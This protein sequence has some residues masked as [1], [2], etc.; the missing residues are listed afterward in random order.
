MSSDLTKTQKIILKKVKAEEGR[1]YSKN[2]YN[3]YEAIN[4][5]YGSKRSLSNALRD[6]ASKEFLCREKD[7]NSY[8]YWLDSKGKKII[9]KINKR[10][11]N[12]KQEEQDIFEYEDGI[13]QFVEYFEETDEGQKQVKEVGVGRHYVELD[14]KR[15]EKFHHE[16]ADDLLT[17]PD[18]VL[19]ACREAVN[20]LPEVNEDVNIRVENVSDI[21]IQSISDLSAKD[22]DKMVTVEAVIQSV[23]KPGSIMVSSIAECQQCGDR[24]EVDQRDNK[25]LK[26]PYKC[27]CGSRKFSTV[28][29]NHKTVRYMR[30]KERPN[31]RS[32]NKMVAV[33]EGDLADDESKNLKAIGSGVK[34]TGYLKPHKKRKNDEQY[35]FRLK[36]NNIEIEENKWDIEDV[37][38]SDLEN[39]REI[40]RRDDVFEYLSQSLAYEEIKNQRLLKKSFLLFLVGR[41]Q[42]YG[43]LHVLCIGDPGT[44][45][46]HLAKY[47]EQNFGKVIKA[48]ATGATEVGLT[49]SVI[50]DE[51]TGEFTA[52]GGSIPMADGGFHITDEVDELKKEY[53]SAFN[54]ALS[55]QTISLAKANIHA[56]LSADVAEYS[57]GNPKGYSFD[58]YE[59]KFKQIPIKKDDLI[60]RYGIILGVESNNNDS[61]RS[62]EKEKEKV[63]HIV[64]R[65]DKS[66]FEDDEFVDEELLA[67]YVYYAQRL[68]PELTEESKK[69]IEDAY[70]SLFK[71]Q[72]S[73]QNFVKPRHANALITLSI[74][75][76]RLELS[77]EVTEDH[78]LSALEFFKK[79]YRSMDFEIGRD[80]LSDLE[81]QNTRKR[82]MV[83][84]A[85]ASG[86]GDVMVQDLIE[87]VDLREE[88]VEDVLENLKREGEVFE[89]ES[90][91]V[92]VM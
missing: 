79:C 19:D 72:D 5:A 13:N 67:K 52:E 38:Q 54:E 48:V 92:R 2:L 74:G 33:L 7:G 82:K 44:G 24:Y 47:V 64:N 70:I 73:D 42:N 9:Q 41:T 6:L 25:E 3:E 58:S 57:V 90:G 34:V 12:R 91:K 14:Y 8:E 32:R 77:N 62:I 20:S 31:K 84:D 29:E 18:R 86:S 28:K 78:V 26:T 45:K 49:A 80:D 83:R 89:P 66:N 4:E 35:S 10:E 81:G 30:I 87:T 23:S 88:E 60:S 68:Y 65:S 56:E 43:N 17:D 37:S 36:A 85:V 15:L 53:Y 46:S 69:K 40:S 71:A 50:K 22:V 76:A 39:I 11:R 59:K 16:L 51:M 21:E 63:N 61:E 27:E 55:D 75:F 1:T